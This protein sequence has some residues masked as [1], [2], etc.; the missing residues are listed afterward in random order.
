VLLASLLLCLNP[1]QDQLHIGLNLV[2]LI[3]VNPATAWSTR[4][5]HLDSCRP[6]ISYV[7]RTISYNTNVD[8]RYHAFGRV[9]Y[10]TFRRTTSTY[11]IVFS[12]HTISY[13][14][15]VYLDVRRLYV[16]CRR[17]HIVC[18]MVGFDQDIVC[19]RLYI[20]FDIA[21]DVSIDLI[22]IQY[23]KCIRFQVHWCSF[24]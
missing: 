21:Y 13:N 5:S 15:I 11:D 7:G 22:R 17:L 4:P 8:V 18:Y 6:T 9:Q 20:V 12:G 16:L 23:S 1:L 10:R 24:L 3:R 2:D 19:S 14:S